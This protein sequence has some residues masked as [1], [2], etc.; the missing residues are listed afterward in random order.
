MTTVKFILIFIVKTSEQLGG[1]REAFIVNLKRLGLM[2][3]YSKYSYI[4]RLNMNK[5]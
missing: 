1:S 5:G 3:K 4:V 2:K